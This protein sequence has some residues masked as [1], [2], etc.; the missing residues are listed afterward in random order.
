MTQ[1][2]TQQAVIAHEAAKINAQ[3]AVVAALLRKQALQ[4]V[5][6]AEIK[7]AGTVFTGRTYKAADERL[8]FEFTENGTDGKRYSAW[9]AELPNGRRGYELVDFAPDL[10]GL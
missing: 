7:A 1:E 3:Q 4:F 5:D 9:A 10:T 6:E 2:Q 8:W